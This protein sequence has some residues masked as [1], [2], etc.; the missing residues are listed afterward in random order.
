MYKYKI[1]YYSEEDSHYFE[2][3]HDLKFTEDQIT[4]MVIQASKEIAPKLLAID[5]KEKNKRY[6]KEEMEV[7]MCSPDVDFQDL[8]YHY[9]NG[10]LTIET[11]LIKNRGFKVVEYE[12]SWSVF[13]WAS[14][15]DKEDW[16]SYR[17]EVMDQISDALN[18][19]R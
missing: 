11:W 10:I 19:G 9:E 16:G 3:E 5:A 14:V 17:S 7:G 15:F 13:G 4:M 12:A 1:G 18:E 8:F 6:T 2:V